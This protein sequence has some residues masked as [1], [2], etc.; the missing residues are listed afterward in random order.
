VLSKISI[1]SFILI[2]ITSCTCTSTPNT[3]KFQRDSTKQEPKSIVNFIE[4]FKDTNNE[5]FH[6]YTP[7]DA[8]SFIDPR[9]QKYFVDSVPQLSST[10]FHGDKP[11]FIF[12][13]YKFKINSSVIAL[14]MLISAGYSG[15]YGYGLGIYKGGKVTDLYRVAE[16]W[17]DGGLVDNME[18]WLTESKTKLIVRKHFSD[19]NIMDGAVDS[20]EKGFTTHIDH[21][22]SAWTYI[23]KNDTYKEIKN[24]K[25]DKSLYKFHNQIFMDSILKPEQFKK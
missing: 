3:L 7:N 2:Y 6:F 15:E 25:V 4:L 9:F 24:A 21:Y 12:P 1:I 17:G 14:T 11:Y 5:Y 13:K 19:A 8:N 22:D 20:L 18:G 23:F 16:E 10:R